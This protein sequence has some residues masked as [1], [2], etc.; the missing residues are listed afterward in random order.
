MNGLLTGQTTLDRKL[1]NMDAILV[2]MHWNNTV[3]L[4]VFSLKKK[5]ICTFPWNTSH[6]DLWYNPIFFKMIYQTFLQRWLL[7]LSTIRI[8]YYTKSING[9]IGHLY[10]EHI[11]IM[12]IILLKCMQCSTWGYYE[13]LTFVCMLLICSNSLNSLFIF[14]TIIS[15][16]QA[17]L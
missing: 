2:T 5:D 10:L 3:F 4:S 13:I 9:M 7:K 1:S 17:E 15:T 16:Y 14:L 8:V 6:Q 12:Y 11:F